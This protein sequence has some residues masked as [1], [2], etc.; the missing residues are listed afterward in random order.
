MHLSNIASF[1]ETVAIRSYVDYSVEGLL[2]EYAAQSVVLGIGMGL[3]SPPLKASRI[4]SL[5]PDGALYDSGSF[6]EVSRLLYRG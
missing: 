6:S 4:G 1:K 2:R 5:D 3:R